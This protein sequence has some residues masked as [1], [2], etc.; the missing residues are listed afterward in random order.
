MASLNFFLYRTLG[1]LALGPALAL[2]VFKGRFGTRWPDRFGYTLAGGGQPLWLHA[3][4]VGEAQSGLLVFEALRQ[5][6]FKEPVLLSAATPAGLAILTAKTK[7]AQNYQIAAPPLDFLGAPARFL[8]RVVPKALIIIE[9]EIWPE[10]F[11]QCQKR[12]IPVLMLSARLSQRS[13]Q[14]LRHFKAF[15]AQTLSIPA[16]VATISQSD[17]DL[18]IDLGLE[19]KKAQVL[20]SPKYDALIQKAAG[21]LAQGLPAAQAFSEKPLILA[22]STHPGEE[23]LILSSIMSLAKPEAA[24]ALAPRHLTRLA[25]LES[26][27]AS[28]GLKPV[29]FSQSHQLRPGPGQVTLVDKIGLLSD[30]YGHCDLAIIGGSFFDRAGH[31]PAGHNPFEPVAYGKALIFGPN[32]L[33]FKREAED[34]E[35]LGVATRTPKAFLN[36]A[37]SDLLEEPDRTRALGHKGQKYLASQKLVAPVLAQLALD[38]LENLKAKAQEN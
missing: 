26:L 30:L 23:E 17:L 18:L 34:L 4:S 27:V 29:L 21:L 35:A 19:P 5:L 22:G 9:T 28:F 36:Q 7:K 2:P 25:E 1:A 12:S 24:L 20:G 14:R 3:A 11:Y 13:H 38:F 6:G 15:M 8:D 32:M 31:N 10:L 33:S 37:I 16:L